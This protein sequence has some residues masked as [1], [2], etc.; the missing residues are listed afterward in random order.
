MS[1]ELEK[2]PIDDRYR[3][4]DAI[5]H[6]IRVR[7]LE[8]VE[9]QTLA[10][11]GLKREL[12]LASNGQLQHHLRKLSEFITTE[13]NGMNYRLTVTGRRALD[14]YKLG[15]ASGT[16]LEA[17]CC[18]P[19]RLGN[20]ASARVGLSGSVL[21]LL[22]AGL[23]FA[24]TTALALWGQVGIR[25][26]GASVSVGGFGFTAAIV[27][28]FFGISFL[29]AGLSR[30]AGCEITAIPNLF[31]GRRKYYSS[32]VIGAFNLPNGRLLEST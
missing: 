26:Y 21:R 16:S 24:L 20:S 19:A 30:D 9:G 12:G 2:L 13:S 25:Y 5:S 6:P 15:E 11:S 17:I 18:I 4:Y 22:F 8:L 23:L 10:F 1:L 7:I 32:C 3:I 27:A 31:A 29:I 14:T 28:G